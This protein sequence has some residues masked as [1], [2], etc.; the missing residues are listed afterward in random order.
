MANDVATTTDKD[1]SACDLRAI[2]EILSY[3][4]VDAREGR[5]DELSDRIEFALDCAEK[6]IKKKTVKPQSANPGHAEPELT[7]SPVQDTPPQMNI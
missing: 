1:E 4:H 5:H 7:A 6:L 3:I 2:F